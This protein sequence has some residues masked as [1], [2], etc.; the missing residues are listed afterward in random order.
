M[1]T[2]KLFLVIILFT[3]TAIL[4][5]E[6]L[7][8]VTIR[9]TNFYDGK[10]DPS[11]IKIPDEAILVIDKGE[12]VE[13]SKTPNVYKDNFHEEI[14]LGRFI[15]KNVE[16]Y[17]NLNDL[18]PSNTIDTFDPSF[19]SDF[20][21][22]NRKTWVPAYYI[23]VLQSQDRNTILEFNKFL[24]EFEPYG[25]GGG[26]IEWFDYFDPKNTGEFNIH[27]SVLIKGTN[28]SM[29]IKNI[30]KTNNGYVVTVK[31]AN[32]NWERFERDDLIWDNVKGK[33]FFDI[34]LCIDGE[35]MDV[36]LDDMEH[37]LITF[38]LVDKIFIK[39]INS[40]A[41]NEEV[42][43]S[44]VHFPR[45]ADGSIDNYLPELTI[46]TDLFQTEDKISEAAIEKKAITQNNGEA[47]TLPLWA[48]F[49]IIGGAAVAVGG[50]VVFAVKMRK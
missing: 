23:T 37:K 34:I 20:G 11:H 1:T 21:N 50:G 13:A 49:A 8:F 10:I 45:R 17:I 3:V 44:K 9:K 2:K 33:E 24:R 39:E 27:N 25:Q 40:L 30:K 28:T 18:A 31:F 29:M 5:G 14:I 26:F 41:E 6:E 7:E 12:K 35:Y 4:F 32:K 46:D 22:K 47:S 15:Y 42:D 43:L 16:Y 48:W 36:Y 38:A 19:I